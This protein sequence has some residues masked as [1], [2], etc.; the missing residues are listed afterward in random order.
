MT[1]GGAASEDVDEERIRRIANVIQKDFDAY[2][3]AVEETFARIRKLLFAAD[4]LAAISDLRSEVDDILRSAV[5]LTHACLEDFLRT[6]ATRILPQCDEK[7]LRGIPLAGV[8]TIKPQY[9]LGQLARHRQKT[10]DAVVRESVA[11]FLD[12]ATFNNTTEIAPC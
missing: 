9:D 12:H 2:D 11:N 5:V 1:L 10:V 4:R 7:A 3:L 8:G 6:I